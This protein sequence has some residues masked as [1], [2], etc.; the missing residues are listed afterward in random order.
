ML[1][2]S[3]EELR[4]GVAEIAASSRSYYLGDYCGPSLESPQVAIGFQEYS[5]VPAI[6]LASGCETILSLLRGIT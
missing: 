1:S 4:H 5:A 3:I 2:I 6:L